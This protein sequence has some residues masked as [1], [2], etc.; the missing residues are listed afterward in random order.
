MK[1]V[2]LK[3]GRDKP[4]RRR[5][6][7]IFSGAI[8]AIEG[9]VVDGDVCDVVSTDGEFLARGYVNRRSQ[10]V[11]RLLSWNAAEAI[12]AAFWRERLQ[13]AVDAR[14]SDAEAQRWVN[15]ESDGLPGLIVDRYGAWLVAQVLTLGM[16]MLKPDWLPAL[17]A[18][19]GER[20]ALRGVYERSDVNVREKEGQSQTAGVL[21]GEEPPELIEIV[22]R[23]AAS[24][25][26]RFWV[27]VRRGHKTGF[28]LDQSENRRRA[29]AYCRD[30]EVLN[31]FSYSGAFALHALAAGARRVVNVDSS[32]DAL[33]LA[34]RNLELNGFAASDEDF[35]AADVFEILRRY[36]SEGRTFDAIILDPPK[37]VHSTGQLNRAT[38][39]YK[40]LNLV[41]MQILREGGVL[42]TFSCSGLVSADLFQKIVFGASLDAR[43][44]AHIVEWLAQSADHAVRLSFPEAAYLKG[45]ALRV[46]Q[47]G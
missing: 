21:Y 6:P 38:R 39:A 40:D 34:K 32:A 13:R 36:R 17:I 15:A 7:W 43:R 28:Y 5:H 46:W 14:S 9:D 35:V 42:I 29:A 30:A 31:L 24:R 20:L 8:R 18:V 45:L 10:I 22:E 41:A 33:A 27:D 47:E 19:A 37:F 3:A 11:A 44:Q 16:E 25:A 26:L 23:D 4:V 2:I 1:R 12:D